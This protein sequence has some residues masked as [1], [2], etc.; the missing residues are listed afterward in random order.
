VIL[1]VL[2]SCVLALAGGCAGDD[3]EPAGSADT[4]GEVTTGPAPPMPAGPQGAAFRESRWIAESGIASVLVI[5]RRD[6]RSF[7]QRGRPADSL[8]YSDETGPR[9]FCGKKL[10]RGGPP[11]TPRLVELR[12]HAREACEHL[13]RA[14]EASMAFRAGK[15]AGSDTAGAARAARQAREPAAKAQALLDAV[16]PR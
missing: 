13:Q 7:I 1:L 16:R 11:P 14:L 5:M 2:L 12:R 6:M 15:P 8:V 4:G 10:G 9:Y 3:E